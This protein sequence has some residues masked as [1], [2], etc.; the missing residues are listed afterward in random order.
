MTDTEARPQAGTQEPSVPC[1]KLLAQIVPDLGR[2]LRRLES[3]RKAAQT[4]STVKRAGL[5]VTFLLG[6]AMWLFGYGSALG[7]RPS[8]IAPSVAEVE[9]S[10]PI[11]DGHLASADRIVPLL[12]DL[13]SQSLVKGLVLHINSPGGAPGDAERIGAAIDACKTPP[14]TDGQK[15]GSPRKVVA[16]ID[17]LG[18]SAAYM[19]AVHADRIVA[20]P[21][22]MVGSIGII[23]EGLK[24]NGL[25]AKVGVTGY[26]YA[27]GPLKTMLSPY[28]ADTDDQQRV[29]SELAHQAMEAFRADVIQR[30]PGLRAGDAELWSGRVWVAAEARRL[31]L[32]DDVGLLEPTERATFPGLPV[33]RFAPQHDVRD[34]LSMTSMSNAL[35][36]AAADRAV[37]VR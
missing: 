6:L 17:G 15:P 21:T 19:I 4:W 32:I 35:V 28:Q 29:A 8:V 27:S 24:F 3:E 34:A 23:I 7:L 26:A 16:V 33:Q 31:G 30:R 20:N 5:A 9:I 25:M 2:L 37:T 10:G 12:T 36:R 13:C 22:G 1:D 11:G 18:A 14:A